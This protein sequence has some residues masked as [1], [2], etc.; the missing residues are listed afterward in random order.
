MRKI[1]YPEPLTN[2]KVFFPFSD[3]DLVRPIN[4]HKYSTNTKNDRG[5]RIKQKRTKEL[6]DE[7]EGS[8][9]PRRHLFQRG[10]GLFNTLKV[11]NDE[12]ICS[13]EN[14]HR[15]GKCEESELFG[16][17]CLG[18]KGYPPHIGDFITYADGYVKM[19]DRLRKKVLNLVDAD[20]GN[21]VIITAPSK[22][23]SKVLQEPK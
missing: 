15:F 12:V 22:N 23:P 9:N 14:F 19:A 4:T 17:I 1:Y 16:F 6:R 2:F 10:L 20:A 3:K 7:N 18:K 5:E 13:C 11:G 21:N 8:D